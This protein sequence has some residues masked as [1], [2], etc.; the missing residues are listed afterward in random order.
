MM[1]ANTFQ[2]GIYHLQHL[3]LFTVFAI[4]FLGRYSSMRVYPSED[5]PGTSTESSPRTFTV[6]GKVRDLTAQH[7]VRIRDCSSALLP[8]SRDM[9]PVHVHTIRVPRFYNL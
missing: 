8:K 5:V 7:Y 4:F 3:P 6:A 9:P 2:Q 1:L